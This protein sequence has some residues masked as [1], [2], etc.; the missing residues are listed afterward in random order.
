MAEGLK[1][2]LA[3][4]RFSDEVRRLAFADPDAYPA[5]YD[6]IE[7][8]PDADQDERDAKWLAVI[9]LLDVDHR[10]ALREHVSLLSLVDSERAI[11]HKAFRS[12]RRHLGPHS[13][14]GREIAA[15]LRCEV[16][17]VRE[18]A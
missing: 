15:R 7:E 2:A 10:N 8:D 5:V 1:Q 13:R 17:T 12:V 14:I 4:A 16:V 3:S 6:E 9:W 18:A 11:R